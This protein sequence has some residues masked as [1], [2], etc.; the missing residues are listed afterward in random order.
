[1]KNSVRTP[2]NMKDNAA[3]IAIRML[4]MHLCVCVWCASECAK[5][6]QLSL[7]SVRNNAMQ[8]AM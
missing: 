1:M 6:N 3:T 8:W 5:L 4:Q 7:N 2:K